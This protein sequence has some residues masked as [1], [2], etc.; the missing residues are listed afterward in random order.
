MKQAYLIKQGVAEFAPAREQFAVIVD[1][2]Q[3]A[4]GL[5]SRVGTKLLRRL[6]QAHFDLRTG[7]RRA[8]RAG[9]V[10]MAFCEAIYGRHVQGGWRVCSGRSR[11]GDVATVPL[12]KG[13]CSR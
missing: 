11:S 10:P 9:A 5:V 8:R 3:S 13:A 6:V 1:Q 7:G 4:A 2:L 12:R